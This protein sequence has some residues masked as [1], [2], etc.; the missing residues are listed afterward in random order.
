MAQ[1]GEWVEDQGE[2]RVLDSSDE[3]HAMKLGDKQRGGT[4][5]IGITVCQGRNDPKGIY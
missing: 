3:V 2:V 5:M 1:A 4:W